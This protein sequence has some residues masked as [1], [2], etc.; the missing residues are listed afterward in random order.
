[1]VSL[2]KTAIHISLGSSSAAVV[3]VVVVCLVLLL[4]VIVMAVIRIR[5][6]SNSDRTT[7]MS[8]EDGPEMEW[9]NS[10]L[11]IT[12]NPLESVSVHEIA[13]PTLLLLT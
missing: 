12:V 13:T 10:T 6:A 11:N 3:A 4:A 1:M 9:D 7:N 8:I 2:Y 5:S